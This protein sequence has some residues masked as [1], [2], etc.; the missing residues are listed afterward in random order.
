MA[1]NQTNSVVDDVFE[2]NTSVTYHGETLQSTMRFD[3]ND[4]AKIANNVG[5]VEANKKFQTVIEGVFNK[6]RDN[7]KELLNK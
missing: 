1:K 2:I 4:V 6:T 7:I 5:P 3:V